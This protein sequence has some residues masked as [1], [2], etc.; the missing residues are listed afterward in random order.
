MAPQDIIDLLPI[1]ADLGWF[2]T[3]NG[4]IRDMD[5]RCPICA[6]AFRLTDG[7]SD[8][9]G[10]AAAAMGEMVGRRQLSQSEQ[11][12]VSDVMSAADI[13]SAFLRVELMRALGMTP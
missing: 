8:H 10:A 5:G 2:E 13:R 3:E 1:V 4:L 6:L 7:I 12:S 11:F 9:R